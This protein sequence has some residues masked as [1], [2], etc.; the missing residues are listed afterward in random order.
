MGFC[1]QSK[2]FTVRELNRKCKFCA[3]TWDGGVN[4]LRAHIIGLRGYGVGKC[5]NVSQDAKD[6]CRRIH[7]K[8][9]LSEQSQ[10]ESHVF[11]NVSLGNLETVQVV[12]FLKGQ[13]KQREH[14][15]KFGML[16]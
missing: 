12:M 15:T 5:D 1:G 3:H 11:G 13:E 9:P 2:G 16:S 4:R 6:A 14:W 7:G 8:V 10:G